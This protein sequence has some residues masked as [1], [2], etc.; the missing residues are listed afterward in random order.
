MQSELT[1]Q[2]TVIVNNLHS[3]LPLIS[4]KPNICRLRKILLTLLLIMFF[5]SLVYL[6][7]VSLPCM[8]YAN[9]WFCQNFNHNYEYSW[10]LVSLI[11]D[12]LWLLITYR[13]YS[14]GLLLFAWLST[15]FVCIFGVFLILSLLAIFQTMMYF[16]MIDTRVL[17]ASISSIVL[18][19]ATLILQITLVSFSL[20]LSKLISKSKHIMI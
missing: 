20:R 14:R 9:I 13:Y 7:F 1:A 17:I 8:K 18:C 4:Q 5:S 15:I 3:S 16:H 19:I 2:Q 10:A 12:G 6:V 11:Y